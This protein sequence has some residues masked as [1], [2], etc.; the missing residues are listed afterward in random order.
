MYN[1]CNRFV[2]SAYRLIN[3]T[4]RYL[5][6]F[7]HSLRVEIGDMFGR[8]CRAFNQFVNSFRTAEH[9]QARNDIM[10]AFSYDAEEIKKEIS[11][12]DSDDCS[13]NFYS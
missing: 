3:D 11:E 4:A 2:T 10:D 1:S 12:M 9:E 8:I 13:P 7:G 5:S 6:D